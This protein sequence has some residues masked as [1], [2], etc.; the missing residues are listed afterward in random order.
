MR[1]FFLV[2]IA[3]TLALLLQKTETESLSLL[4][5]RQSVGN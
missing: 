4:K 2:S 3:G 1:F 5:T